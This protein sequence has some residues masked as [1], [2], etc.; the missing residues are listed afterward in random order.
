M[1]LAVITALTSIGILLL[2]NTDSNK[3]TTI[4]NNENLSQATTI[5]AGI[6]NSIQPPVSQNTKIGTNQK[7]SKSL[8]DIAKVIA[9]TQDPLMLSLS[10]SMPENDQQQLNILVE[11]FSQYENQ[12][13]ENSYQLELNPPKSLDDIAQLILDSYNLMSNY[14]PKELIEQKYSQ[15]K[16][17]SAYLIERTRILNNNE[18][19][20]SLKQQYINDLGR[21]I[22]ESPDQQQAQVENMQSVLET[23]PVT[24]NNSKDIEKLQLQLEN[25]SGESNLVVDLPGDNWGHELQTYNIQKENILSTFQDKEEQNILINQL[26]ET[27]F[28]KPTDKQRI[29]NIELATSKI[30]SS[31]SILN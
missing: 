25:L 9:D 14:L 15:N 11:G 4:D 17:F 3:I 22:T 20:Y 1:R 30:A 5:S 12:L 27:S 8:F 24:A 29:K 31:I 2:S 7:A 16:E 18:L 13:K 26:Q 23:I 19:S 6:N 28:S 10:Q 21:S